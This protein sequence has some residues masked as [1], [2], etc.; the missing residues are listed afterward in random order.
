L[1]ENLLDLSRL[2]A[3]V[4]RIDQEPVRLGRTVREV[5]RKV[6]L[7]SAEHE[8]QLDWPDDDP[9]VSAD[10]RRIYQ[11][12]QNLITNAV[13]YSPDGG[14]ITLSAHIERRELLICVAD[15]G[16]GLPPTEIDRIFDRFHRVQCE[17]S[18]G[19]GGTGLGLAICKG[20]VEAHGG[21]IWAESDGLGRGSA[22]RFTLPLLAEPQEPEIV[23]ATPTRSKGAHDHQEANRPRRR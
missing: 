11:V 1:I 19:I 4:L 22:F 9:L 7:A 17:V 3:G 2:E 12:L 6:Q 16:L 10:A 15:E 14:C 8:I 21:R 20:L 18:R 23:P 13:K 5:A